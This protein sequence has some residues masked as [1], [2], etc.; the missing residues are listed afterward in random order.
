[1][2]LVYSNQRQQC[3]EGAQCSLY[4]SLDLHHYS[5]FSFMPSFRTARV[6]QERSKLMR[7]VLWL[8]H[9][10]FSTSRPTSSDEGREVVHWRHL[11]FTSFYLRDLCLHADSIRKTGSVVAAGEIVEISSWVSL[12]LGCFVSS[13]SC[14]SL[15]PSI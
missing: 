13:G 3:V 15:S 10:N 6:S 4:F 12:L 14:R 1:M 11:T 7:S 2:P 8:L 9:Y 5:G